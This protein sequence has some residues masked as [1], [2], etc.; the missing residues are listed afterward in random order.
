[1]RLRLYNGQTKV[2]FAD[3]EIC[4]FLVD[5]VLLGGHLTRPSKHTSWI[6]YAFDILKDTIMYNIK[7]HT[8][9]TTDNITCFNGHTKCVYLQPVFFIFTM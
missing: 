9:V 4:V 3:V 1:M 5:L 2:V 6:G 8:Y 7:P